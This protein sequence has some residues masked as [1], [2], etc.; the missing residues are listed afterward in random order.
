M[1]FD[2]TPPPAPPQGP[3]V[4]PV[5]G[6]VPPAPASAQKNV[7]GIVA[8][9]IAAAG[10]LFAVI[11]G[12]FIVGWLLLPI[13]LI[14][15]IVAVCLKGKKKGLGI[16]AIIVAVVGTIAGFI[17]FS[18]AAVTAIDNAIDEAGGGE[19]A[20][21]DDE[22]ATDDAATEEETSESPEAGTRD[23]PLTLGT[24]VANDDWE[25]VVN[26]VTL[27]ATDAV[28]AANQFNEAPGDG[29]EY[30]LV[31]VTAKNLNEDAQMAAMVR[32]AYVTADG[33]TIDGTDSLAVAPDALDTLTELY[34]DASVTG[35]IA[36][37]VPSASAAD[38]TIVVT[39]GLFGDDV[40]YAAQ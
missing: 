4:S 25:V 13:G 31:N 12:M 1:S 11:P 24:A 21:V 18:A 2:Q 23:N 26:S 37:A 36:F 28:M 10:F 3:A 29:E 8:L 40:F 27:G 32:V 5:G 39:P 30:I 38:G 19:T 33:V 17:A 15:G 14:L 7:L 9:A 35:N 34:K 6:S 20:V 16:A 22:P